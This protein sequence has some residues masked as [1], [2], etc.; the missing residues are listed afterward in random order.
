MTRLENRR[1]AEGINSSS[2]SPLAEFAILAA[3]VGGVLVAAAFAISLAAQWLAP[4]VPYRYEAALAERLPQFAATASQPAAAA[5][6][7]ELQRLADRLARH[8]QWPDGMRVSVGYRD[9]PVV[10][11]FAT[12][13]GQLVFFRGLIEKIESEDALAMVMAHE[14]AHLAHRHPAAALG[15]GV[16]LGVLLSVVSAD[17]GSGAAGNA[18]G[19]AGL[20]T[21]MRFNRDQEREADAGALRVLAAEYGH[22]AGAVELF[23]LLERMDSGGVEILRTHPLGASRV[24]AVRDWARR[25]AVPLQGP[26]RPL[27]PALAA[28][29][30]GK[31]ATRADPPA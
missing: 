4:R 25:E 11:A 29:R 1:P 18:L 30:S 10:N 12:L 16:G 26:A 24:D 27:P 9:E 15:R 17:L 2:E 31:R 7:A 21:V 13:G 28:L 5:A 6:Q 8:M 23:A 22:L 19:Q 14:L 20:A 3:G